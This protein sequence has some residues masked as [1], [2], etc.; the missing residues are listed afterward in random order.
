MAA[1]AL[2]IRHLLLRRAGELGLQ[3]QPLI[4]GQGREETADEALIR[5]VLA[6]EAPG[7]IERARAA[8]IL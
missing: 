3:P 4:D 1:R 2:V 5:Q 7:A 8:G 6:A